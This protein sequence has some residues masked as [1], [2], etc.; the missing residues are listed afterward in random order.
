MTG[1]K[2][3]FMCLCE[4]HAARRENE[5]ENA[6]TNETTTT[7]RDQQLFKIAYYEMADFE[8]F[9]MRGN[10]DLDFQEV[11]LRGLKAMLNK[12]YSA[13]YEDAITDRD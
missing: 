7:K 1:Q 8:T 10:D 3:G 13:G 5:K 12:A 11:S 4:G 9:E 6:M 2:N